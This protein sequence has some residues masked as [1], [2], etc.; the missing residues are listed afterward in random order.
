MYRLFLP[1]AVNESI[2]CAADLAHDGGDERNVGG[3]AL[4]AEEHDPDGHEAVGRPRH[5]PQ[6]EE[7]R[8]H[9]GQGVLH[10]IKQKSS[11]F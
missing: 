6:Q 10:L 8:S 5:H 9:P 3:K 1:D 7:E 4:G 11:L 2:E